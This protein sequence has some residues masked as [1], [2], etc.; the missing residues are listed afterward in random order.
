M[1]VTEAG[2]EGNRLEV[3]AKATCQHMD[4]ALLPE[5]LFSPNQAHLYRREIVSLF[6]P[7]EKGH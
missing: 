2:V 4:L 5:E 6:S 3:N 7:F 1:E